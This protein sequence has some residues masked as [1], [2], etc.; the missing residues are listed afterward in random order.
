MSRSISGLLACLVLAAFAI[1]LPASAQTTETFSYDSLGRLTKV[2][3]SSGSATCYTHDPADNRTQVA[4][5]GTACTS[6]GGGGGGNSP[7]VAVNDSYMKTTS[8]TTWS[9]TLAVRSNDTDPD[10]PNDTLTITTV[11]GSSHAS[12]TAG[13]GTITISAAPDGEYVL[14]YT[15]KDAANATSSATVNLTVVSLQ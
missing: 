10:L 6:G 14:N 1:A 15:I 2:T 8:T 13:G 5:G 12:V 9:G 7:P 3:P 4:V 11:S